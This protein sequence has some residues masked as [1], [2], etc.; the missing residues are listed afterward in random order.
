MQVFTFYLFLFREFEN[1]RYYLQQII[2][3]SLQKKVITISN[4]HTDTFNLCVCEVSE[5]WAE[6][7]PYVS[8]YSYIPNFL[9]SSSQ[10]WCFIRISL[11]ILN[12]SVYTWIFYRSTI[13][14]GMFSK[15]SRKCK[16]IYHKQTKI[17]I[18]FSF[19][20]LLCLQHMNG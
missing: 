6:N 12:K 1:H 9:S 7:K 20:F 18:D 4:T 11:K 17:K 15:K 13:P 10:I 5:S 3:E 14:A 2:L 16:N 8:I 19:R